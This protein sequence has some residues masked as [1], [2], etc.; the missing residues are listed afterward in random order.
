M[1]KKTFAF[2][3]LSMVFSLSIAQENGPRTKKNFNIDWEFLKA[4]YPGFDDMIKSDQEWENI[5]VR[6][7]I[8]PKGVGMPVF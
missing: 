6:A 4:N 3:L 5:L 8:G 7:A 1:T 2:L